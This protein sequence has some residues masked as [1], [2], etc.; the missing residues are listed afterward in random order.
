MPNGELV[1]QHQ[2][3]AVD[4]GNKIGTNILV[5]VVPLRLVDIFSRMA[6]V[7][8]KE[9]KLPGEKTSQT[10]IMHKYQTLNTFSYFC[11]IS[12]FSNS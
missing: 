12:L 9:S 3:K 7:K 8:E 1:R 6:E 4:D 11:P 5:T 2:L 10:I